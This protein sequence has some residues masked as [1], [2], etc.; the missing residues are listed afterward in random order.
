MKDA[1]SILIEIDFGGNRR[2]GKYRQTDVDEYRH[3][4]FF[5]HY[6]LQNS[7]PGH[8][9][10]EQSKSGFRFQFPCLT[11]P[12]PDIRYLDPSFDYMLTYRH[13]I[14]KNEAENINSKNRTFTHPAASPSLR[15]FMKRHV[16]FIPKTSRLTEFYE[17]N[18]FAEP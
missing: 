7:P 3:P 13:A 12:A 10:R 2:C 11:P 1:G 8:V 9:D 5:P 14:E 17:G 6:T 15:G 18:S 4:L 16:D